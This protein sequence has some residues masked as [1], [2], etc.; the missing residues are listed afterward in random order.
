MAED[1]D[2]TLADAMASDTPKQGTSKATLRTPPLVAAKAEPEVAVS[3]PPRE[4]E[5][6][7]G[8]RLK[9][10]I[11]MDLLQQQASGKNAL[12][13]VEKTARPQRPDIDEPDVIFT[14]DLPPQANNIRLDGK[15]YYNGHRYPVPPLQAKS[16]LDIQARAWLH[17]RQVR[18]DKEYAAGFQTSAPHQAI[19]AGGIA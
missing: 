14:V 9:G 5:V 8:L 12:K 2:K 16:M 15:E 11:L 10:E 6:E 13:D 3:A 1:F 4:T 18:G 19:S 7:M 17:Y